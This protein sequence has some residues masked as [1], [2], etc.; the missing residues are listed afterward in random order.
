[1]KNDFVVSGVYIASV[2]GAGFASGSEIVCY[3]AAHGRKGFFGIVAA[4]VLFAA[5]AAAILE[6]SQKTNSKSWKEVINKLFGKKIAVVINALTALF[7]LCIF[8]AMIAGCGESFSEIAN[9]PKRVG[10]FL[11]LIITAIILVFDVRGFMAANSVMAVLIVAGTLGVCMYLFNFREV[12][13]FKYD[14][15]WLTSGAAY[16]GYNVLTAGTVLPPISGFC[17]NARRVGIISGGVIFVLLCS[18]WGIISIYYGKIDLGV[19]PMLT[20][21]RRHGVILGMIYSA[22]LFL[23]M[24]TTAVANAFSLTDIFRGKKNCKIGFVIV[25][26][27][28]LS[29]FKFD[30]FV[31]EIYRYAGYV[32]VIIMIYIIYRKCTLSENNRDKGIKKT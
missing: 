20:L 32:G 10:V 2:I 6:I 24:L 29:S 28:L 7:M 16:A 13:V 27:L 5:A 4:S 18:L 30:F 11:I 22:V 25:L 9:C 19:F 21:S 26:G 3:F 14:V 17:K 1:M 12:Y 15:K 31:G 8:A 23:A